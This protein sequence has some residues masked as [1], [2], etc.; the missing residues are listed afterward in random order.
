MSLG[1]F[2]SLL[3]DDNLSSNTSEGNE[4]NSP[5][6][7]TLH[8][9]QFINTGFYPTGFIRVKLIEL[10]P[11]TPIYHSYQR[12]DIGLAVSSID[13]Y[14]AISIKE[15]INVRANQTGNNKNKNNQHHSKTNSKVGIKD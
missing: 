10:D 7:Y 13:P 14:C 11:A 3:N 6:N 9:Q 1:H 4:M 2:K 15:R 5:S 12:S 8:N